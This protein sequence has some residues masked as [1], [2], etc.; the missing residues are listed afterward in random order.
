MT[1]TISVCGVIY[2][3]KEVSPCENW[4]FEIKISGKDGPDGILSTFVSRLCTGFILFVLSYRKGIGGDKNV[5]LPASV[6]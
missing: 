3:L 1:G 4:S 5:I 2:T 6:E